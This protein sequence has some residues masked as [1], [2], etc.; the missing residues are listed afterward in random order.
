MEKFG[1]GRGALFALDVTDSEMPLWNYA[2]MTKG[3]F[4]GYVLISKRFRI[5]FYESWDMFS[6][7]DQTVVMR[8]YIF[9]TRAHQNLLFNARLNIAHLCDE[10]F[11]I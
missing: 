3:K 8:A 1:L 7:L 10:Q 9:F 6:M 2:I 4:S 11:E 5:F